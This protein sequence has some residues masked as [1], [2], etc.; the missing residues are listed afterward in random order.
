MKLVWLGYKL[1]KRK[2]P[3][4]CVW[5]LFMAAL[6]WGW[7]PLKEKNKYAIFVFHPSSEQ[8]Q[9]YNKTLRK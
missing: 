5:T 6:G 2:N 4:Q 9:K 1:P 3:I 7:G 8:V